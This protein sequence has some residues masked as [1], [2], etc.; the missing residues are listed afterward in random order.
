MI[1]NNRYCFKRQ[2]SRRALLF[3]TIFQHQGN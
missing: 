3:T 1:I 2:K